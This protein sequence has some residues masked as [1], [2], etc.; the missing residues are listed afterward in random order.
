MPSFSARQ[1]FREAGAKFGLGRSGRDEADALIRA[2]QVGQKDE[3]LIED[4]D[5][6]RLAKCR[7]SPELALSGHMDGGAS[8]SSL[9][10]LPG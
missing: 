7:K 9:P 10:R 8:A 2:A 4:N 3:A 1:R 5:R 6:T